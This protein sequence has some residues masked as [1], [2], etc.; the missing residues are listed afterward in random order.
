MLIL[1]AG[2]LILLGA[3]SVRIVAD[4][5]RTRTID[6]I[7]AMRWKLFYGLISLA[8]FVLVVVGF[9]AAR[10]GAGELW[11]P[12]PGAALLALLLT[13]PAFILTV[14]GYVPGSHLKARLG[15]PMVLGVAL[16]A[17]AHLLATGRSVDVVLFG[18]FL[19]WAVVDFSVARR[20]DREAGIQSAPGNGIRDI[21]AVALGTFAWAAFVFILH[22]QL[23]GVKTGLS[24]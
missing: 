14:A 23:I 17:L 2:L 4:D 11:P 24:G 18:A 16:W 10:A 9:P 6:S 1:L 8:G 13:V 12:P 20:R 15:H 19:I 22:E 3:H 7:G 21:I 5:W